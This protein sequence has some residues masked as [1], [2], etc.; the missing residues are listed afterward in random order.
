MVKA[1]DSCHHRSDPEVV[2]LS[3]FINNKELSLMHTSSE[4]FHFMHG[5][6]LLAG[7]SGSGGAGQFL[8]LLMSFPLLTFSDFIIF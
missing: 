2:S 1:L 6:Q 4:K 3:L 7:L 8:H 5:T